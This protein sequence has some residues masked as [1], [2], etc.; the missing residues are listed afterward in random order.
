MDPGASLARPDNPIAGHSFVASFTNQIPERERSVL[1][2]DLLLGVTL[3]PRP[4]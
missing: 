3:S 1:T 2:E 4:P